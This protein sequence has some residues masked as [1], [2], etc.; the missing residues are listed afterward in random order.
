MASFVEIKDRFFI[1]R[2]KLPPEALD[3]FI[4]AGLGLCLRVAGEEGTC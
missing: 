3:E 2:K 4:A 1:E